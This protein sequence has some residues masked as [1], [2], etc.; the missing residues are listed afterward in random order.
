M[1]N[2]EKRTKLAQELSRFRVL[3]YDQLVARI[4][5]R[6]LEQIEGTA[7][8]GTPYQM[9]FDVF[10]DDQ[11]HGDIRVVGDLSVESQ[12]PLWGILPIYQPDVIE[13]FIMTAEGR[14]VGED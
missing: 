11:P 10:W 14:F 1:T 12:R 4:G 3:S 5:P 2:E 6:H 13:S 7:S 8:D 9:E